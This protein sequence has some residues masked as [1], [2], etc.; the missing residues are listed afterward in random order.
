MTNCDRSYTKTDETG[1]Y[2]FQIE[3]STIRYTLKQEKLHKKKRRQ[4][5][6]KRLMSR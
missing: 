1:I 3:T 4:T 2:S 5:I 6:V